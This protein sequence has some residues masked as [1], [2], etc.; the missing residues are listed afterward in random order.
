MTSLAAAS[1]R[2]R[3]VPPARDGVRTSLA[4]R[5]PPWAPP[6][7]G[8]VLVFLAGGRGGAALLAWVAPVALAL[9]AVR[10]AGRRGRILL[11]VACVL[12]Y[13]AQSLKLVTPPVTLPF[14][15]LFGVPLGVV[16]WATLALWDAFRRW[17]GWAWS[18]PVLA[19]LTSLADVLGYA[20]SPAGHWAASAASQSEN[21]PLLQLASLGGLGLVGAVMALAIG[22]AAALLAAPPADRPWRT[23]LTA[24]AIAIAAHAFGALR[25]DAPNE[26]PTVRVAGV[27]VDFPEPLRTMEDLRGHVD[28]LFAR[29]ELAA[30]R[31]AEL[32]VWNE[33]ATIV[34]PGEEEAALLTRAATFARR[35]GVDLVVAYGAVVSRTPFVIDNAYVWF[36]PR[37]ERLERYRKHELPPGE[38][39]LRGEEPL[40]VLERPW[41][42]AAGA[43]CYDYD[44]PWIARAH[45]R[46]GA[47]VVA[48]PASDW[49]GIDPQHA[50]MARVRAIEGGLSVVRAARASTSM[51]F[52]A[53]GRIRA[54]LSAWERNERVM[55]ATVPSTRVRTVY[56]TVGDA[57]V[58]VAAIGLLAGAGVAGARRRGARASG[59][60]DRTTG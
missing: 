24:A 41:G 22:A 26:G 16:A 59:G 21:L 38:P 32:V 19:A 56:A 5:V 30:R 33:V 46:G 34:D 42:R 28:L 50:F 15:L 13:S 52:D 3:P 48:L 36:G 45:A 60:L 44:F 8:I 47:G 7:A 11:L 35:H 2:C 9:A 57:P 23:A 49:R 14:A 4:D 54:S 55:L 6:F 37:G 27:T 51:A 18:I 29:S 17:A 31:G 12:A 39:S 40:R 43:I 20:A 25:L 58:V 10:L 1:A 53:Y